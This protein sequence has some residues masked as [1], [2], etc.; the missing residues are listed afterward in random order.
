MMQVLLDSRVY[1]NG[2]L[3]AVYKL[4]DAQLNGHANARM[5]RSKEFHTQT[6]CC[7]TSN[8]YE[9]LGITPGA[10]QAQIK[11]AYYRLSKKYH[12]DVN[13]EESAKQLFSIISEA[14]QV[15]GNRQ[16][17]RIY[18]NNFHS[19]G[20]TTSQSGHYDEEYGEFLKRRDFKRH[21]K[22]FRGKTKQQR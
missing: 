10:S 21:S 13:K 11:A 3:S 2:R 14:Y 20:G 7:R 22:I 15:L 19:G 5:C 4:L 9:V 1:F 12:P 18:D 16:S 17:R 8:H 6:V